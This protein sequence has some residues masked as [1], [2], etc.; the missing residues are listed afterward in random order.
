[1]VW[2]RVPPKSGFFTLFMRNP[3]F[4]ESI[5]FQKWSKV[6]KSDQKWS[7][8]GKKSDKNRFFPFLTGFFSF[9]HFW[10]SGPKNVPSGSKTVFLGTPQKWGVKELLYYS[11]FFGGPK[12]D[13]KIMQKMG[14]KPTCRKMR[15]LSDIGTI[16]KVKK[17]PKMGSFF[18]SKI[19]HFLD[20][21]KKSDFLTFAKVILAGPPKI[22]ILTTFFTFCK[23][24]KKWLIFCKIVRFSSR[25]KV[26]KSG[27][28]D[29]FLAIL[30]PFFQTWK[31]RP[32]RK[33]HGYRL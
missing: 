18:G 3:R 4:N 20:P 10:R 11:T 13:P 32:K 14:Q 5:F 26:R 7:K 24:L 23:F 1:M 27:K 15:F 30:G 31:N 19:G 21:Q 25:R 12:N 9:C 6:I 29:P 8:S 16:E 33:K 22:T 17:V 2:K 28:I